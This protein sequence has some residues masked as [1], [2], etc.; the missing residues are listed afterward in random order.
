[1]AD[2]GEDPMSEDSSNSE[3]SDAS[4]EEVE[5]SEDDMQAITQ[6]EAELEANPNLYDKHVEVW[7]V[8]ERMTLMYTARS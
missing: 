4:F 2:I 5:A 6:L 7:L 8:F 3:G 1:M